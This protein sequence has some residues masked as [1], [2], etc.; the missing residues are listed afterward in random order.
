MSASI[1]EVWKI[2]DAGVESALEL[3]AFHYADKRKVI[4]RVFKPSSFE[5][6]ESMKREF[7]LLACDLN[8]K[9][10]NIYTTINAITPN[11]QGRSATDKDILHRSLLLID[12]DR[13]GATKSPATDEDIEAARSLA[14]EIAAHLTKLGWPEPIQVMSGNGWH[15]Y[16]KLD[17]L[18]NDDETTGLIQRV[19]KQF[20]V[21]N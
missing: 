5:S 13:A 8:D 16:Y 2:I 20:V 1:S 9:G 15:L 10:Y 12:I 3:R 7:E 18:S 21:V 4:S 17:Q 14:K 6:I 11:L 19:L